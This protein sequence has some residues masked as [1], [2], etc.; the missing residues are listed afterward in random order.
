MLTRSDP[1]GLLLFPVSKGQT[2]RPLVSPCVKTMSCHG[3]YV[4]VFAAT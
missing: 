2:L 4:Y 1:L 3:M